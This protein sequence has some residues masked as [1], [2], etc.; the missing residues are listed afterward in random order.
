MKILTQPLMVNM[1]RAVYWYDEA[2]QA[3]LAA[4]GW[5]PVT[6]TQSL[7]FANISMGE[8][9][10]ARLAR[11]MGMTR[12][13]MSELINGIV[14]RGLLMTK[15]DPEDRRA[16][17]VVFQPKGREMAKSAGEA[18][19]FVDQVLAERIGGEHFDAMRSALDMPWGVPPVK[20]N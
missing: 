8:T 13:S 14:E 19:D 18:L 9:R 15:P 5:P 17:V 1:L 4:A 6:R 20:N 2:L 10:P 12:Q 11:N 3:S 16:Q 7:L